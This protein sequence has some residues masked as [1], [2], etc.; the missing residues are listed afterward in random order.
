MM[1]F[2]K[3]NLVFLTASRRLDF[4]RYNKLV[5]LRQF[6]TRLQIVVP[7]DK[8]ELLLRLTTAN[9]FEFHLSARRFHPVAVLIE[10][11]EPKAWRHVGLEHTQL[12]PSVFG[13]NQWPAM[14]PMRLPR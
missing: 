11:V 10:K 12:D 9:G 2:D 6:I 8:S 7:T 1:I 4:Q 13:F 3:P 5:R 14:R